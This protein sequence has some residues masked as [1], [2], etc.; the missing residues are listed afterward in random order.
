VKQLNQD[1]NVAFMGLLVLHTMNGVD[2]ALPY[3]FL[4][5]FQIIHNVHASGVYLN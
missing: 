1:V 4:H 3:N 5:G 2:Q